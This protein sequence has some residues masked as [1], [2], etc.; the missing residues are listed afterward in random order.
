MEE[1]AF[2]CRRGRSPDDDG[3]QARHRVLRTGTETG[4]RDQR[5]QVE[6]VIEGL[7]CLL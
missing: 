6:E 5:D 3:V 2:L 4:R 7:G 1:Q